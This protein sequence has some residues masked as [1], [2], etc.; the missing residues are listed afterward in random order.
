MKKVLFF[1]SLLLFISPVWGDG[2]SIL[3]QWNTAEGR[4]RVEIYKCVDQYCGRIIWLKKPL[5]PEDDAE[6]MAGKP[7]VDREN[8]DPALRNQPLLG[9]D[10]LKGFHYD[11]HKWRDGTIYDPREGKTYSCKITLGDKGQ[12]KVRGFIGFSLFGRT[13]EWTR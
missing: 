9:M 6:G 2:D 11:G 13:T 12:L 4:S 8:P 7:K 10:I 5:Y 3:G 1:A